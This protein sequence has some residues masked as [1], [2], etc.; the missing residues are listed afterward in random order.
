MDMRK[1]SSIQD[2]SKNPPQ[3]P[4]RGNCALK[5][6]RTVGRCCY[7]TLCDLTTETPTDGSRDARAR[8]HGMVPTRASFGYYYPVL[9]T[10]HRSVR[11]VSWERACCCLIDPW[12][13]SECPSELKTQLLSA[14]EASC[15]SKLRVDSLLSLSPQRKVTPLPKHATHIT[16]TPVI[17]LISHCMDISN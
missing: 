14:F 16:K 1:L 7:G 4:T 12:T 13:S 17:F 10:S 11:Q 2:K 9:L 6:R 5:I 3:Y 15:G 8:S